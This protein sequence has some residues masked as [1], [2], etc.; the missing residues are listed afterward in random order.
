MTVRPLP[1][2]LALLWLGSTP[3]ARAQP[4]I[5]V[6]RHA[7]KLRSDNERDNP[8][9]PAGIRRSAALAIALRDAGITRVY[10]SSFRRT[11]QTAAPL[12]ELLR[13]RDPKFEPKEIPD[14]ETEAQAVA[15]LLR[16]PGDGAALIVTH[17]GQIPAF[18]S[19]LKVQP[20]PDPSL[21][22][23]LQRREEFDN[24]FLVVPQVAAGKDGAR[25][26]RSAMLIRLRYGD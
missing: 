23:D 14:G 10:T 5:F 19:A 7:E 3:L 20:A 26:I 24:L 4:V 21:A 11:K 18:L 13:A 17:S 12:V 1:A 8:L 25:T 2:F 22:D 6:V 15:R 16:D 9:S